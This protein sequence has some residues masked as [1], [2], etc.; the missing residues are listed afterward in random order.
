M[1]DIAGLE[2]G[3]NLDT[4]SAGLPGLA[5]HFAGAIDAVHPIRTE[6]R[7]RILAALEIQIPMHEANLARLTVTENL[8][9]WSAYHLGL[10][11]MYRFNRKDNAAAAALFSHAV[12]RDPGFAGRGQASGTGSSAASWATRI[13][14]ASHGNRER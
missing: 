11:H 10:Q 13:L 12:A 4:V 9:A 14:S 5:D 3:Q 2:T 6:I 8:D 1:Q 7:S